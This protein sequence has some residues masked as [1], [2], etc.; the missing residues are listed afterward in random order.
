MDQLIFLTTIIW[1]E[2]LVNQGLGCQEGIWIIMERSISLT[3][4][5]WLV[6][7]V[8]SFE[9]N[10]QAKLAGSEIRACIFKV[11]RVYLLTSPIK[12]MKQKKGIMLT[13]TCLVTLI[14]LKT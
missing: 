5:F 11:N 3:I 12:N 14:T 2:T 8:N 7:S 10:L 1:L 13:L 6:T 9:L 4:I